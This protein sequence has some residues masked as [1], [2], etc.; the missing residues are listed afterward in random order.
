MKKDNIITNV[1]AFFVTYN[2][3]HCLL[4]SC[5]WKKPAQ[6]FEI[7]KVLGFCGIFVVVKS[8]L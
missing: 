4:M 3:L 2:A 5:W 1:K 8:I 7:I 6:A